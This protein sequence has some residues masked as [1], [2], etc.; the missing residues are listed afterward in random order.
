MTV[1]APGPRRGRSNE[2]RVDVGRGISLCYEELGTP[3]GPLVVLVMGLGLDLCWWRD[4]FCA[5]LGARGF[6]VVRFDNRDVGRSTACRGPG[7]S[8]LGFLR[9]RATPTYTLG[10]MADDVAV[11]I[12]S[13]DTS[14]AHVVGVS[15]GSFIA[16]EVAIRHPGLTRSVVSIMGRPGDGRT[17]KVSRRMIPEFLR[18]GPRDQAGAIEH[19]VRSFHR[20]GSRD[21]TEADDEDVRVVMRRSFAREEGDGTGSGR[22]L[23]AILAER[24]RTAD[25]GGLTMPALVVHGLHDRVVLP[26]G[27]RAT[28]AA[29]PGAEL[30]E[31][32]RMG[33]DLARWT[34][35]A[36]LDGIERT[37]RRAA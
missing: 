22:Q 21:R 4:D 23:A 37:A 33:H 24:D 14:G 11:L 27:G 26:S 20:I 17:G 13:L 15:L 19:L 12:A 8:A 9:R 28:A 2:Q 18:S 25:L 3:D 5:D 35:P 30:L 29:I 10:D 31:I 32:P 6:R 16:Q 1:P 34:W 7:V 36:V